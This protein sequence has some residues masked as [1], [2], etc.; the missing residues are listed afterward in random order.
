MEAFGFGDINLPILSSVTNNKGGQRKTQ[1]TNN[2]QQRK[3]GR[4]DVDG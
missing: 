1:T 2:K 4:Y 3:K